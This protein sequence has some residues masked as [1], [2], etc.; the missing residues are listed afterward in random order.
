MSSHLEQVASLLKR[1]IQDVLSRGLSDPRVRGLISVTEV[2]VS[3]DLANASVGISILPE[4]HSKL[5]LKGVQH[6]ASHIRSQ[7]SASVALRRV[8]RLAFHLDESLKKQAAVHAAISKAVGES[9]P[10]K[11]PS[12]ASDST[13]HQTEDPSP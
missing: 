7:V 1:A 2:K 3:P 4:E 9:D 8:P 12:D 10:S 5:T 13:T 6:A 11:E